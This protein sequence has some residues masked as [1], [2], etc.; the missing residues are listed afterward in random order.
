MADHFGQKSIYHIIGDSTDEYFQSGTSSN[1]RYRIDLPNNNKYNR[2]ALIHANFNK[3]WYVVESLKNTFTLTEE[4]SAQSATVTIPIGSYTKT[5]FLASL[6]A[7][8][9]TASPNGYTYTV[10]Y[11]TLTGKYTFNVAGATGESGFTFAGSETIHKLMGFDSDSVNAFSSNTIDSTNVINFQF[12]NTV[13]IRSDVIS[14]QLDN[15]LQEIFVG[16]KPYR[17]SIY[18][19]AVDLHLNSKELKHNA[20]NIFTFTMT[21]ETGHVMDLNGLKNSIHMTLVFYKRDDTSERK[22]RLIGQKLQA[23]FDELAG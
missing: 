12:T 19:D 17:S 4:N 7:L 23:E 9:N 3:S 2:V 1:F 20:S 22:R 15:I 13:Q 14:G 8:L 21:D 6:P 11:S 18:Y 5:T 16:D 10:S